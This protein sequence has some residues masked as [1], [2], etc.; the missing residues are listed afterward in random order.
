MVKIKQNNPFQSS[1][2]STSHIVPL[3]VYLFIS[4][5]ERALRAAL[6]LIWIPSTSQSNNLK[7]ESMSLKSNIE[8]PL[9]GTNWM[10]QTSGVQYSVGFNIRS[11][12][13][14]SRYPDNQ[15]HLR[16][17]NENGQ[18]WE[19]DTCILKST[20]ANFVF[21]PLFF[22]LLFYYGN[23]QTYKSRRVWRPPMYSWPKFNNINS[24]LSSTADSYLH[25]RFNQ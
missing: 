21:F 1:L 14:P 8:C 3:T 10:Q 16:P 13:R 25:K 20:T 4:C 23:F 15:A 6:C 7:N 11:S 17:M 2:I 22:V 9:L 18:E 24:L 12:Y 19:P 5:F